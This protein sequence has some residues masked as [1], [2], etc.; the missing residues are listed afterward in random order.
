MPVLPQTQT[1]HGGPQIEAAGAYT[2]VKKGLNANTKAWL[3]YRVGLMTRL[4][5]AKFN[6]CS[7]FR[8]A[9]QQTG[10]R[11]LI[12]PVPDSFWGCG[13][14]GNGTDMFSRL[15]M[16][17]RQQKFTNGSSL[18]SRNQETEP[19]PASSSA[20]T[21]NSTNQLSSRPQQTDPQPSTSG[22]S[23]HLPGTPCTTP[24]PPNPTY[25]EA[26]KKGT[27]TKVTP[28]SQHV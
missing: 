21:Q 6:C 19:Q 3:N 7:E 22:P 24:K 18:S 13:R 26:A 17:L 9:L 10:S 1:S 25:A 27:L 5:R 2:I 20:S 28:P 12:H 11:K 8:D 16:D 23:N 14:D 15:L 4:L